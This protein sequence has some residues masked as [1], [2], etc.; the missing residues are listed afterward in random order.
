MTREKFEQVLA[1]VNLLGK[2]HVFGTPLE[3]LLV[4]GLLSDL[5]VAAATDG[6]EGLNRNTVRKALGLSELAPGSAPPE[7]PFTPHPYPQV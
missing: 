1:V 5:C 2:Q 3:R 6:F 4:S 7:V